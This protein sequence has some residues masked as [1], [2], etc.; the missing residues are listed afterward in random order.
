MKLIN[1]SSNEIRLTYVKIECVKAVNGTGH[2]VEEHPVLV[3]VGFKRCI[4]GHPV[5]GPGG[6]IDVFLGNNGEVLAF[7]KIWRKLEYAGDVKVIS[8]EE[9]FE[10]LK[11]GEV[12]NRPMEPLKIEVMQVKPGYYARGLCSSRNATVL[13]GYSTAEMRAHSFLVFQLVSLLTI[14]IFLENINLSLQS[15]QVYLSF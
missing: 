1:K 4:E 2:V 13:C 3:S 8:A 10:K 9:A 11:R 6:E 12:V 15:A 7:I 14:K 5:V